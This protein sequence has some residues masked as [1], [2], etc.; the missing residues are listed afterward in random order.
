VEA[1]KPVLYVGGGVLKARAAAELRTL[2]EL[3]AAPV[4]TTL[5]ARGAF[6]DSH[7]QHLGMPGMH[8][9]VAAVTALQKCDIIIALGTRFDDRVTGKL[10][11]FAPDAVVIHADIDPAEI[12]KNRAAD[13]PIVGDA[14]EVIADLAAAVQ[15]EIEAG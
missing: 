9:A 7:P 4:I 11:T 6:P 3:V 8:G 12:S 15:S 10:S 1:S 2:A 5:M 13:V 14:R